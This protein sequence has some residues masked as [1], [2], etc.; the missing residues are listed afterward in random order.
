MATPPLL[1]LDD[2]LRPI[3]DG[4]PSGD[5]LKYEPEYDQ[6]REARRA[7][8]DTN[9][10]DW[11][12]KVKAADW[13]RV[14]EFASACLRDK[15][16]D[17][18]IAAWIAEALA[19][20]H[21]FAGLRDG[22]RLLHGLL[23]T[24][25]ETLYPELEDD[26]LEPRAGAFVF[27]NDEKILPRLIRTLPLT[28]GFNEARY[29]Q[30]RFEE[31]RKTQNVGKKDPD[32]MQQ[33]IAEGKITAEQFD[34][35]VAQTP[36]RFYQA[37]ADDLG[38]CIDA[39]QALDQ[40][41]DARYKR[42]APGLSMIRKALDDCQ[43]LVDS[44]VRKKGEQAGGPEPDEPEPDAEGEEESGE[45][46]E[47]DRTSEADASE[48]EP[49]ERPRPAPRRKLSSGGR[50]GSTEDAY[51]RIVEAAAYLRK[52]EPGHPSAYLVIRALRMG[53]LY[54]LGSSP[55]PSS[56]VGPSKESRQALRALAAS[57]S[58]PEL[59]EQAEQALG[60]PEGR[61]WLDAQ[62]HALS[63]LAGSGLEAPAAAVRGFLRAV[64]ADFPDLPRS[65]LDDGT[66]TANAETLAWL[67][68]ENLTGT[69]ADEAAE[70]EPDRFEPPAYEPEPSPE[71]QPGPDVEPA[72]PDAW[73]LA[74]EEVRSG[75]SA[76]AI[77]RLR[78]AVNASATGREKFRR[79][80]QLAELCLMARQPRVAL[81]LLDDLAR[82]VD[83][84]RLEQ[85]EDEALCARVWGTLY[86]CLRDS[87][88]ADNGAADRLRVAYTR[89]CRLDIH[90]ALLCGEDGP[91]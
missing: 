6:I 88:A 18:Q 8:D 78:R 7:E 1:D 16:K 76:D 86:R 25:W 83:E 63:A 67:E 10:G 64:L 49:T 74:Q 73:D 34:D 30:A 84:F 21:A 35:A 40:A 39:F 29:S 65:E 70:P 32:Q 69:A 5:D 31:S 24:F 20:R 85:W 46:T 36:L 14:I 13:I 62:R 9:Q 72:E 17:L 43:I 90:Q 15:S 71:S 27:L 37:L 66:P 12:R 80:L 82:Q 22:F 52:N 60:G 77:Q 54:G 51:E 53:E 44:F 3:S 55:D 91:G 38:G 33:L 19:H 48:D 68:A 61:A 75:R 41:I 42:E 56:L 26:D 58:W 4:R 59:I 79:K 45:E 87:G 50:I 28:D 57:E 23:E 89:L 81:P 47:G 11:E 2:L